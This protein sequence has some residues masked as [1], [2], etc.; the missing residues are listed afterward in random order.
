MESYFVDG[1]KPNTKNGIDQ[2]F[3]PYPLDRNAILRAKICGI[4]AFFRK[5]Y[6]NPHIRVFWHAGVISTLKT[7]PIPMVF[8][9][10]EKE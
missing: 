3:G 8:E 2:I 6:E 4:K 9:K 5:S 1:K 7:K 10:N